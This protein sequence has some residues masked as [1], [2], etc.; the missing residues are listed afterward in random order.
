MLINLDKEKVLYDYYPIPA[1]DPGYVCDLP[2][3]NDAEAELVVVGQ[4]S[5]RTDDWL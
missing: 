5:M 1:E 3:V 2:S 4:R